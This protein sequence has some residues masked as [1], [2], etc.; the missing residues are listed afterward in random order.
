MHNILHGHRVRVSRP[1][2]L[3]VYKPTVEIFVFLFDRMLLY[4]VLIPV[5]KEQYLSQ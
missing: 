1:N 2:L 3:I 4:A 5:E